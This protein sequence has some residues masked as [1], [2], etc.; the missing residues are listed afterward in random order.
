MT[1]WGQAT[2]IARI[3]MRVERRSG[4][5]VRIVIPFALMAMLVFPL[6]LG[7]DLS[8]ISDVGPAVFWAL[9]ILFG[10]QVALRESASDD[11]ARKDLYALNGVD[12]AARFAGR[13]LSGAFLTL[14]FFAAL[15]VGLLV[16][17]APDLP[18]GWPLTSVAALLVAIGLTELGTLAGEVTSNL[19]NR[20]ALASLIVAPLAVPLVIG[21]SQLMNSLSTDESILP[22]VLLL[23]A[24]DLALAVAGVGLARPLEEA[25]R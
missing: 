9:G 19:R 10:M 18:S 4:E 20:T 2:E 17:F 1:F 21:G 25:S 11:D 22:W 23:L 6:A 16:I 24:T 15:M 14:A 3:D 7:A 8:A 12:P 5:V 13:T